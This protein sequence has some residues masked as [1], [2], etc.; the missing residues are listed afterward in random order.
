MQSE[1]CLISALPDPACLFAG[2]QSSD[3]TSVSDQV[4]LRSVGVGASVHF[5]G[6]H[7]DGHLEQQGYKLTDC[8]GELP[9]NSEKVLST[10][11]AVMQL[12]L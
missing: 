10:G 11:E 4:I 1:S 12:T 7:H 6:L 8:A 2:V 3:R 5:K 9:R